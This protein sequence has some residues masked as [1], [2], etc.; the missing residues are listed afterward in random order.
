MRLPSWRARASAPAS[1]LP[2]REQ[3]SRAAARLRSTRTRTALA[4]GTRRKR[5]ASR[6]SSRCCSRCAR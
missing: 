6:R 1:R 3:Q 5:S 2:S 4:W